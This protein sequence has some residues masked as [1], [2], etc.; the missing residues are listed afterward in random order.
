MS[1]M[2]GARFTRRFLD[3]SG[4]YPPHRNTRGTKQLDP[5]RTQVGAIFVTGSIRWL[6]RRQILAVPAANTY[7]LSPRSEIMT[8]SKDVSPDTD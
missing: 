8:S 6:H 1:L 3:R 4:R 2:R 5:D 7:P